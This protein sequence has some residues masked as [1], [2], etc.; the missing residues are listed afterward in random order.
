VKTISAIVIAAILIC[1]LLVSVSSNPEFSSGMRG[2]RDFHVGD[3]FPFKTKWPLL[4]GVVGLSVDNLNVY[5]QQFSACLIHVYSYHGIEIAGTTEPIVLSRF[6]MYGTWNY[7]YINPLKDLH[8]LPIEKVPELA[9]LYNYKTPH[10]R[11]YVI[12][13]STKARWYCQA[14]FDR[15]HPE[16]YDGVHFYAFGYLH[17]RK[18]LESLSFGPH[19]FNLDTAKVCKS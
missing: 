18:P 17:N 3:P 8:R 6:E 16:I 9:E 2:R 12:D 7:T 1:N 15:F 14:K 5:I 4:H 10:Q 13:R 11:I 19:V